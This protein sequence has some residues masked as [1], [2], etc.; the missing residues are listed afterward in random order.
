MLML[1]SV[2]EENYLKAIFHLSQQQENV[3]T[4]AIAE[5]LQTT[6]ASVSD[7]LQK[8]ARKGVVHY[9]KY[10]GVSLSEEG[11]VIAVRLVR[12]HRLWE[13]FLVEKLRFNWDEVHE[14]AEQL[15]HIQSALM[16]ERLDEFLGYPQFDPHGDPIPDRDGNLRRLS[17]TPLAEARIGSAYRVVAVHDNSSAFLQYLSKVGIHIGTIL[18]IVERISFDH[19]IEVQ[20]QTTQRLLLSAKAAAQILLEEYRD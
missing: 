20:L 11:R 1:F 18:R 13:V 10:K 17:A 12:R 19:S 2:T 5:A 8:L 6:A 14:V 9:A 7:M 3:P 16:I 4:N 15:E